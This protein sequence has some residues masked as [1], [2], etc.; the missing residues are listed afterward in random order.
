MRKGENNSTSQGLEIGQDSG[1]VSDGVRHQVFVDGLGICAAP[2]CNERAI[3]HRTKLAECAHIIPRRVGSHPRE[4]YTTPLDQRNQEPNLL[5]LCER[6]HKIVDNIA[7]AKTYTVE[8]L[9]KWKVTHED[10][11]QSVTKESPYLPIELKEALSSMGK[12]LVSQ[13][14]DGKTALRQLIEICSNLILSNRITESQILLAQISTLAIKT[15]DS[16]LLYKIDYLNAQILRASQNIPESKKALLELIH[17]HHTK[18]DAAAEYVEL[19]KAAPEPDD[20]LEETEN[21]LRNIDPKNAHLTVLDLIENSNDLPIS[22]DALSRNITTSRGLFERV[23][24]HNCV[25]LDARG[26]KNARDELVQEWSERFE[27]SSKPLLFQAVFVSRDT[28]RAGSLNPKEVFDSIDSLDRI[29]SQLLKKDPLS[30][31]DKLMWGFHEFWPALYFA[32][33]SGETEAIER[34]WKTLFSIL[35]QCYFD[36]FTYT[37]L[38]DIIQQ[39]H[40]SEN[41]WKSI[42]LKIKSSAVAPPNEMIDTLFLKGFN[43]SELEIQTSEMLDRYGNPLTYDLW[44]SRNDFDL[45]KITHHLREKSDTAFSLAYLRSIQSTSPERAIE[46]CNQLLDDSDFKVDFLFIKM[47]SLQELGH[48]DQSIE[49]AREIPIAQVSFFG[50]ET[51]ASIAFGEKC[52][53]LFIQA[54]T[55]LLEFAPTAELHA[56]VAMAYNQLY[57]D[58][59]AIIHAEA[60]LGGGLKLNSRYTQNT[61]RILVESLQLKGKGDDACHKFEEYTK[62]T[63]DFYTLMLGADAY[64]K[65]SFL[66]KGEQ[67]LSLVLRAFKNLETAD[68]DA[69]LAAY[70]ATLELANCGIIK[71][72]NHAEVSDGSFIKVGGISKWFHVGEKKD[73]MG[74]T[75]IPKFSDNYKAVIGQRINES[76]EWPADRFSHPISERKIV[77]IV[78]PEGFLCHRAHEA[79]EAAATSG[80]KPIWAVKM[81]L[82]DGSLDIENLRKFSTTINSSSE[83]FFDMFVSKVLPFS[84]LCKNEGSPIQ[85]IGK[86]STTAK[87]FV[88]CNNGTGQQIEEQEHAAQSALAGTPCYIDGL[89]ALILTDSGLLEKVCSFIPNVGTCASVVRLFREEAKNLES[90]R[91]SVGRASFVEHRIRFQPKD[92]DAEKS[93]RKAFL[94]SADYLDRLPIKQI[95]KPFTRDQAPYDW[96]KLVPNYVMDPLRNA[97]KEN[98]VVMTED[99]ILREAFIAS[100]ESNIPYSF[101]SLSVV[102]L[103]AR[104]RKIDWQSYYKY[105]GRLSQLRFFLLPIDVGDLMEAVLE[106]LAGELVTVNPSNLELLNLGYT[107]SRENGVDDRTF[108]AILGQFFSQVVKDE[109]ISREA[110]DEI[111]SITLV[112]TL[113]TAERAALRHPVF[114]LCR[115]ITMT[116]IYSGWK[117]DEKMAVLRLQIIRFRSEFDPLVEASPRFLRVTKPK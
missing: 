102:R 81:L 70:M 74:A 12:S 86:I 45:D 112:R 100:G 60:A 30:Q 24:A 117:C 95:G 88:R 87:G 5:Y 8:V 84:F 69:Y 110:A 57:D 107:L 7:H 75:P 34:C 3:H 21:L 32:Q 61:L 96:D 43:R 4:D 109:S 56:K 90:G 17:S 89:A 72:E 98:A 94:D 77:C 54:S 83:K 93:L 6:H 49:I 53:D 19:C 85:A 55:R 52:W 91:T 58:S 22:A 13:V 80:E 33:I 14:T 44:K 64:L 105:F 78:G 23:L 82:E 18:S 16:D 73:S 113:R 67:A 42:F 11:A 59:Q 39:I 27:T 71:L 38:N 10:W 35:E 1:S 63:I 41:E 101:S 76:I 92:E 116:G 48:N 28:Q 106:P 65:S 50:I 25:T 66:D 26:D 47:L 2:D 99:G 114:A 79:L 9:R 104:D 103:L 115:Q 108:V 15:N 62:D 111:F 36:T 97:Q 51:V 37:Y 20:E 29:K 31:K 40:L 68:D 46:L